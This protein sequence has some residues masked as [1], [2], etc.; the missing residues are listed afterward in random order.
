MPPIGETA[1]TLPEPDKRNQRTAL[2]GDLRLHSQLKEPVPLKGPSQGQDQK[3]RARE[4]KKRA[5]DPGIL[6]ACHAAR[7][8][9]Y[10][11]SKRSPRSEDS[12]FAS[13][14]SRSLS[15]MS[16]SYSER[17]IRPPRPGS[18]RSASIICRNSS[19]SGRSI[20]CVRTL[21]A[22]GERV[23]SHRYPS[24]S[25]RWAMPSSASERSSSAE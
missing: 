9:L 1:G 7:S 12:S 22:S 21:I 8:S 6:H 25:G 14:H 3:Y 19:P 17:V 2:A 20:R 15:T 24:R 10:F 13:T 5:V 18:S 16:L 23:L 11:F 4:D